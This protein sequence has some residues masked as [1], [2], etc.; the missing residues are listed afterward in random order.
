MNDYYEPYPRLR[1]SRS[2]VLAGQL[3]CGAAVIGR[4]IASR[5]GLPFCEVDRSVEHEVGCS[6]ARLAFEEG[7][8]Y[9]ERRA[10]AILTRLVSRSPFG[11]V[12]L[13]RAWLPPTARGVLHRQ[14]HFVH[15]QRP[16][17]YL[18]KRLDQEIRRAGDWVLG[19][20][21]I[22]PEERIDPDRLIDR[23]RLLLGE[24]HVVLDAGEQHEIHVADLLL[25]S[26]EQVSGA[27]VLWGGDCL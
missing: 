1:L 10:E 13:D 8:G 20:S 17:E 2:V 3:G 14:T 15:I 21:S 22:G 24:A 11:V 9:I 19:G 16:V 26:L 4:H 18:T 6:L 7:P 25:E 5:T 23:R 27:A 12:V